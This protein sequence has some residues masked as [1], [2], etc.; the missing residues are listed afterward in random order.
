MRF[1]IDLP[2][3]LTSD[4]TP[5]SSEGSYRAGNNIRF[6]KGKPEV[7][8]GW[9]KITSNYV[10]GA[11]RNVL[12]WKDNL[13]G[14][15]IALASDKGLFVHRSGKIYDVTPADYK[16]GNVS[17]MAGPGFG[18]GAFGG[19][20]FGRYAA[21]TGDYFARTWALSNFGQSLIA[22]YRRGPIYWLGADGANDFSQKAERLDEMDGAQDV[23]TEVTFALVAPG[24]RQI[25]ALGCNQQYDAEGN[26]PG[27]FNPR[28][29]RCSDVDAGIIDWA[30]SNSNS[31]DE[32][33]LPSGGAIVTGRV[34]GDHI[35]VLSEEGLWVLTFVGSPNQTYRYDLIDGGAGVIGPNAVVVIGPNLFWI[36]PDLQVW[37]CPMGGTP[38]PVI[39]PILTDTLANLAPSQGDKVVLSYIAAANELRIDYPDRRD[40]ENGAEGTENSRY[41][42]MNL[43]DSSWSSGLQCRTAFERGAPLQWPVAVETMM[44]EQPAPITI[45]DNATATAALVAAQSHIREIGGTNLV[46]RANA[47]GTSGN[48][49]ITEILTGASGWGIRFTGNGSTASAT[50]DGL[51][52]TEGQKVSVSYTAQVTVGPDVIANVALHHTANSTANSVGDTFSANVPITRL[53]TVRKHQN[54]AVTGIDD[55]LNI[56]FDEPIANGT[57]VEFTDFKVEV[58]LESTGWTPSPDEANLFTKYATFIKR[59]RYPQL[60]GKLLYHEHGN[61]ADEQA[62]PWFIESNGFSLD[63][64][65]QAMLI[66]GFLPDFRDQ[67]G[68]VKLTVFL[69][70]NPNDLTE[71]VIGPFDILPGDDRVDFLA[72]AKIARFRL[73]GSSDPAGLR[74]GK[75]I[76]DVMPAGRR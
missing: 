56:A 55:V 70:M 69:K 40:G 38:I 75:C 17:S 49:S 61:R 51:G 72:T 63:E 30:P 57:V 74:I 24:L 29:I 58:G 39:C 67:R 1:S 7:V 48:V 35:A 44:V 62:L 8:A 25:L 65:L 21:G 5:Y 46:L 14:T 23:P 53:P 28:T 33:E 37:V 26:K 68:T 6:T 71:E 16:P 64:N 42:S 27:P 76:F 15:Q 66:R 13:G 11:V 50:I 47:V 60:V 3:G 19:G 32:L 52:L 4:D 9:E 22:N 2:P 41:L 18:T 10:Q 45:V 59:L 43:K 54:F 12:P 34:W 36:A 20:P 31:S 73:E